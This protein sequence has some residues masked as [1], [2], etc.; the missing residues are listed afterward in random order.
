VVVDVGGGTGGHAGGHPA[1]MP[2]V[3][4][5]LLDFPDVVEKAA[6]L[7]SAEL[8]GRAEIVKG[9]MTRAVPQG[10][11]AYVIKNVFGGEPDDR[12]AA[13]R[14]NCVD[15]IALAAGSW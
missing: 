15:A 11:D 13:V 2:T 10:A 4:G 7:G 8:T 1:G 14:R 5:I 3:R 9:D 6:L 12:S